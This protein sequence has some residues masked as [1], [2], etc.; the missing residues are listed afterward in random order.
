MKMEKNFSADKNKTKLAINKKEPIS[1]DKIDERLLALSTKEVMSAL[2]NRNIE[3]CEKRVKGKESNDKKVRIAI[4][5]I[6]ENTNLGMQRFQ[7]YLREVKERR[8]QTDK[9]KE[10]HAFWDRLHSFAM[11]ISS[12]RVYKCIDDYN[13][14]RIEFE[15]EKYRQG[16]DTG[17]DQADR[18]YQ[19]VEKYRK[20][21]KMNVDGKTIWI[22]R[23]RP[24]RFEIIAQLQKKFLK[25]NMDE[26][27]QKEYGYVGLRTNDEIIRKIYEKKLLIT[28]E[29]STIPIGYQMCADSEILD[30]HPLTV[31]VKQYL[32]NVI[33]YDEKPLSEFRY[34]F[35][36]QLLLDMKWRGKKIAEQLF[37]SQIMN[38]M[39]LEFDLVLTAVDE[40][41]LRSMA[42][43]TK[44][45]EME[46]I[47]R[48]KSK[49][50]EEWIILAKNLM[51]G[52]AD[53]W[54][55]KLLK[56]ERVL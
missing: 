24:N 28:A 12:S 21:S 15:M 33:T 50:G 4:D 34:A 5:E 43:H 38:L 40:K 53:N 48:C 39:I 2:L 51:H 23:P 13:E 44:K 19:S 14:E 31:E 25:K 55:S 45:L 27:Q 54:R 35:F 47:G 8:L 29:Y 6:M 3:I 41:N 26:R 1:E 49:D 17:N 37:V 30:M 11:Q 9:I 20:Q 16:I 56:T 10:V 52:R 32:E 7:A 36:M 22:C 46:K 18:I 42:F